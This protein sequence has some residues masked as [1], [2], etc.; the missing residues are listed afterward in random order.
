MGFEYLT[1]V[2]LDQAKKEYLWKL[3]SNGFRA[4]LETVPVQE[5]FGRITS[6]AVYARINAPHYAA[7]AMDGVALH[8]RDSFGATETTPVTLREDQFVVVDTGDPIPENCDAVIMVEDIVKNDN[9]SITIHAAAA[10]WQHVR[11]NGEDIC[12]IFKYCTFVNLFRVKKTL[13]VV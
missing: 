1:N 9:G 12:K 7:S 10:P 3:Q 4:Q 13:F 2:P 11:Q 8:A 5:S 6:R